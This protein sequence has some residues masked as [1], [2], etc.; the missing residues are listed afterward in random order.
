MDAY[1]EL[2]LEAERRG[3]RVTLSL[4]E[5]ESGSKLERLAVLD[6]RGD[7]VFAVRVEKIGLERGAETLLELLAVKRPIG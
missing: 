6:H 5:K 2:H 7:E 1:R 3:L 4:V